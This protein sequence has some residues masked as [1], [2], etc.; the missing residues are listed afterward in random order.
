MKRLFVAILMGLVFTASAQ[1]A[2]GP[3]NFCYHS[4]ANEEHHCYA[5]SIYEGNQEGVAAMAYINTEGINV[6][7]WESGDQ[8][9]NELWVAFPGYENYIETGQ[10]AGPYGCCALHPFWAITRGGNQ[11]EITSPSEVGGGTL[12]RYEIADVNWYGGGSSEEEHV[13]AYKK[14]LGTWKIIWWPWFAEKPVVEKTSGW[15]WF[16]SELNA[17]MEAATNSQPYN[18]GEDR[19]EQIRNFP[20]KIVNFREDVWQE[21]YGFTSPGQCVAGNPNYPTDQGGITWSTCQAPNVVQA[22]EKP[23]TEKPVKNTK[24]AEALAL[25]LAKKSG[26]LYPTEVVTTDPTGI[27]TVTM[28]NNPTEHFTMVDAVVPPRRHA[29]TGSMM[30]VFINAYS[31]AIE[32]RYVGNGEELVADEAAVSEWLTHE[33]KRWLTNEHTYRSDRELFYTLCVHA[34]FTSPS[35]CLAVEKREEACISIALH[36][37][38][39][40]ANSTFDQCVEPVGGYVLFEKSERFVR[41]MECVKAGYNKTLCLE[42]EKNEATCETLK[43][44]KEWHSFRECIE[45]LGNGEALLLGDANAGYAVTGITPVGY[46]ETFQFTAKSTGTVKELQFR[47]NGTVNTGVTSLKLG[48]MSDNAGKPG[49]VI[50]QGT[51]TGTE[52]GLIAK[53]AWIKVTGLSIPALKGTR[54]WL[55]LLP[56]GT[57]G[58]NLHYNVGNTVGEGHEEVMSVAKGLTTI[59]EEASWTTWNEGPVGF[60]ALG[61]LPGALAATASVHGYIKGT[62]ISTASRPR[63]HASHS[64]EVGRRILLKAG[65]IQEA[66]KRRADGGGEE[67]LITSTRSGKNGRFTLAARPG[68]YTLVGEGCPTNAVTV[69]VTASHTTHVQLG[70]GT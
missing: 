22:T 26:V 5:V 41:E 23:Y 66:S 35:G 39:E 36:W 8:I 27:Y 68:T 12:N 63:H 16:F 47:T 20:G 1:A 64:P 70:C 21:S 52:G 58:D 32:A 55:V 14:G 60:Q 51:A 2:W 65:T 11:F 34:G 49:S 56:L 57:A 15:P 46:E 54:Y 29:P 7:G 69:H 28:H 38:D 50:G 48:I 24:G 44:Y 10:I 43:G 59:T 62:I 18:F 13:P 19:V 31:G 30:K 42:I 6:P 3:K 37:S 17:G 40:L 67:P 53:G 4:R 45:P 61:T 9:T 25:S 33:Q